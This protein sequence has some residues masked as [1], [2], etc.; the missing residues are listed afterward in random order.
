MPRYYDA[1]KVIDAIK[2]LFHFAVNNVA[3]IDCDETM[4]MVYDIPTADVRE[5]KHGKWLLFENANYS[6]FD[7]SSEY[8]IKCSLCGKEGSATLF[9]P[10]CGAI[11]DINKDG[12]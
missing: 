6:S 3:V 11:M 12:E 5:N 1:E 10:N 8:I 2:S 4:K 9:C 7:N